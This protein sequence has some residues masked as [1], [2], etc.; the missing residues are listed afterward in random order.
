MSFWSKLGT[1]LKVA[2]PIA[3]NF[4]PGVGPLASMAI[5]GAIGAATSKGGLKERLLNG[6][7]SAGMSYAGGKL[8]G[9][10]TVMNMGSGG[11]GKG[12]LDTLRK[13]IPQIAGAAGAML[14]ERSKATTANRGSQI[15]A[16]IAQENQRRANETNFNAAA[17]RK[18]ELDSQ[19]ASNYQNQQISRAAEGRASGNDA[20]L[21]LQKTEYLANNKGPQPSS[22]TIMG[23]QV[24]LPQFDLGQRASTD[25]E[26]HGANAYRDEVMKRLDG[27]N[28]I[29]APTMGTSPDIGARPTPFTIPDNLTHA[30]A[31]EQITG[32]LGTGLSFYDLLMKQQREQQQ[33]QNTGVVKPPTST[34]QPVRTPPYVEPRIYA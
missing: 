30:G 2:A 1:G 14:S 31:G 9:T 26:V 29:T 23:K 8:P 4:I 5:S 22:V 11:G 17:L 27:G 20:F 6:G 10:D 19:N 25:A 12:I 3:A 18:A 13:N 7:I 15:D 28:P 16:M 21:N 34:T 33:G 24:Q 32:L